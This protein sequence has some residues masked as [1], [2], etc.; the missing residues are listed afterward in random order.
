M[1]TANSQGTTRRNVNPSPGPEEE[2]IDSIAKGPPAQYANS[3]ATNGAKPIRRRF[4]VG[5]YCD[6]ATDWNEPDVRGSEGIA[7]H[8]AR[9]SRSERLN[10]MRTGLATEYCRS[11]LI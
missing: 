7:P 11:P 9:K 2:I 5:A 8:C 4:L 3:K 1:G 6:V 10:T